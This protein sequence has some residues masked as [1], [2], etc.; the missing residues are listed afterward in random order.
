MLYTTQ[1]ITTI[2]NIPL[3]QFKI[4]MSSIYVCVFFFQSPGQRL[5]ITLNLV[6][7]ITTACI[8]YPVCALGFRVWATMQLCGRIFYGYSLVLPWY[9][10]CYLEQRIFHMV[11]IPGT[12]LL[13]LLQNT[14]IIKNVNE[15]HS[16]INKGV[17]T[18]IF[19]VFQA[20]I[21]HDS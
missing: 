4:Y 14:F 18:V 6:Q 21:I 16:C 8:S 20:H 9:F 3:I 10:K 13:L 2:S 5:T 11:W 12:V 19:S 15:V 1:C 17:E 7:E